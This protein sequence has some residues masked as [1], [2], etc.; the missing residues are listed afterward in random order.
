MNVIYY[1]YLM[2]YFYVYECLAYIYEPGTC[3][4][5]IE[6]RRQK[7]DLDFLEL[8]L[9][10]FWTDDVELNLDPLQE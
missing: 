6:D 4:V 9:E 7:R 2:I 3:L 10:W 5:S 1:N 8:V